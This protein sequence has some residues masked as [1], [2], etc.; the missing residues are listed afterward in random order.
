MILLKCITEGDNGPEEIV[1]CRI[2]RKMKYF[3]EDL[4]LPY[5]ETEVLLPADFSFFLPPL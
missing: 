3:A 5:I 4:I 1:S 2:L